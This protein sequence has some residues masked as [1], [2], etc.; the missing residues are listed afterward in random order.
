[1][2][3]DWPH[4]WGLRSTRL[5]HAAR[6]TFF[7]KF[8]LTSFR[9]FFR[10]LGSSRRHTDMLKGSPRSANGEKWPSDGFGMLDSC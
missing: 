8:R 7:E 1:M 2:L 3:E 4:L 6:A 9:A 5:Q 10:G